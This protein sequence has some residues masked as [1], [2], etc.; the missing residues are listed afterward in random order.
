MEFVRNPE[1]D[2]TKE[3]LRRSEEIR[4]HIAKNK[5]LTLGHRARLDGSFT[6]N[7]Y[8]KTMSA[9]DGLLL[10]REV[11]RDMEGVSV[12]KIATV[13][14]YLR[15]YFMYKGYHYVCDHRDKGGMVRVDMK[16][17]PMQNSESRLVNPSRH[18]LV[19]LLRKTSIRSELTEDEDVGLSRIRFRLE[20]EIRGRNKKEFAYHVVDHIDEIVQLDKPRT[21]GCLT[22]RYKGNV[23]SIRSYARLNKEIEMQVAYICPFIP[24]LSEAQAA[25]DERYGKKE[26]GVQPPTPELLASIEKVSANYANVAREN[27]K[28]EPVVVHKGKRKVIEREKKDFEEAWIQ[29]D[30]VISGETLASIQKVFV[31][32]GTDEGSTQLTYNHS[33]SDQAKLDNFVFNY[34]MGSSKVTPPAEADKAEMTVAIELVDSNVVTDS[35]IGTLT[36][37]KPKSP[38]DWTVQFIEDC[39]EAVKRQLAATKELW[40]DTDDT[41]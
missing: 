10:S 7:L 15:T 32:K 35:A 1:L 41:E 17:A 3:Q 23:Y 40:K 14:K 27:G 6:L 30:I 33:R 20:R 26:I 16:F 9:E 2:Y 22:C 37:A 5:H 8:L 21:T 29:P 18:Q 24:I 11:L 36:I 38:Q 34:S 12:T 28:K 19:E 31:D 25:W 39:G 13:G 4:A